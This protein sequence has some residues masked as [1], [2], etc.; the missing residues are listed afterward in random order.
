M[1]IFANLWKIYI[2]K[3][4]SE[5]YLIIPILIPYYQSHHLSTTQIYVVQA[6]YALAVLLLEVPSGYLSDRIGRKHTLVLGALFFP[7]GIGV[8]MLGT[9]VWH[10]ILA[11]L[12]IAGAN[13]MRSGCDSALIYDTLLSMKRESDYKKYEG[14]S[15]FFTRIGTATSSILG[16]LLALVSLK[17]PFLINLLTVSAMLPVALL[18]VEPERRRRETVNPW[19]DILAISRFSFNHPR[20][21]FFIFYNA[22]IMCTNIIALWAY[23]IY[24]REAGIH[25]GLFGLIFAVYQLASALG[26]SRA[27]MLEEKIGPDRILLMVFFFPV[28]YFSLAAAKTPFFIPLILFG[29]FLWGTAFPIVLDHINR[30]ITSDVRATVISIS[31]MSGSFL[32]VLAAPLFGW[33]TDQTSLSVAFTVL[34]GLVL[35][36]AFLLLISWKTLRHKENF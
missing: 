2:Y 7:I 18:L 4:L 19:R 12:F 14:R 3:F 1:S 5:F 32:Y 26:S 13:S 17:L 24:Y 34:G 15:I 29:A 22:V 31:F 10:F 6:T 20:I 16:G 27:H 35:T 11:E 21:R 8:Y 23:F 9:G 28:I 30:D 33:L 36:A 25:F